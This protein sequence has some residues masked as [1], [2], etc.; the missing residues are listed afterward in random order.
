MKK[1]RYILAIALLPG[2]AWG[3]NLSDLNPPTPVAPA[4]ATPAQR[5]LPG[6]GAAG[7]AEGATVPRADP[8]KGGPGLR[9]TG[10]AVLGDEEG[11]GDA[12]EGA[13]GDGERVPEVHS[14]RKGDTLWDISNSYFRNPWY[15]PKL[16]S[17]NPLITN[18]HWIYPNDLVRLY[19]PGQASPDMPKPATQDTPETPRLTAAARPA[20]TGITLRQN[21]FVDR[22]ELDAAASIVGSREEKIMLATLDEAYIEFRA[23]RPLKNGER[24]TIYRVLNEVKH[25]EDGRV[26]GS[27]VEI[28]GEV[29]VRGITEGRMARGVILDAIEP[30]ERGYR[31]G[32]LRRQ[33]KLVDPQPCK[34]D[35]DAVVVETLRPT[36]LVGGETLIFLDRGRAD[37][38]EVGNRLVAVRRGDGYQPLRSVRDGEDRRFPREVVAEVLVVDVRDRTAAGIV[39]RTIKEVRIGE[40][41][42]ARKGY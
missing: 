17:F 19:P 32:P 15:W 1:T 20:P 9:G 35:L 4:A 39:I 28:M 10:Q 14:V 38:L 12:G 36:Q 27:I 3:Q 6:L 22:G 41:L 11:E 37:Q 16:W 40:R 24:Y 34:V 29:E 25:P 30:I 2:A 21:G 23:D 26:L 13:S 5:L 8:A 42:E 33:F 18:P 31:V 7:G